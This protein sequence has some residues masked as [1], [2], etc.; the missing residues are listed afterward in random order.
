MH[1]FNPLR[2]GSLQ[3]PNR[4]VFLPHASG[5]AR[6]DGG[7]SRDLAA[8]YAAR[9]IGGAGTIVLEA[10]WPLPPVAAGAAHIALYD[11]A[12]VENL[13]LCVE[14]IHRA[15][16]CALIRIDQPITIDALSDDSLRAVGDSWLAAAERANE[17]DFD[18]VMLSCVEG[19]VFQRL[20]SP[21]TNQR[22]GR[23]GGSL[24][25]RTRLLLETVEHLS[26]HFGSRML[27]GLRLLAEEF[28]PG[29]V[30]LQDA[31]VIARRMTGAGVRLIE[32]YAPASG[33]APMAQFPGWR[34]PL[35][36]AIRSI[37]DVPIILGDLN[38][39]AEFASSLLDDRSA[40]FAAFDE[41]LCN[42][43]RWPQR[44]RVTG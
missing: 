27:I 15:G 9:A 18:G 38:D 36:A 35:A 26:A 21:L 42:D 8:F 2:I 3:L 1:L 23:Y 12:A 5:H 14:R 32:V 29:G 10:G 7:V 17:A 6:Y 39:D 11:D 44:A 19:G 31:R 24:E 30:T 20:L 40:D 33:A 22:S 25:N 4:I 34:A 13:A 16:S 28:T 41:L 43:P 37:A